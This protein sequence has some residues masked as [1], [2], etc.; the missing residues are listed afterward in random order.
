MLNK[1]EIQKKIYSITNTKKITKVMEMISII[2]MKKIKNKIN[3]MFDYFHTLTEIIKKLI[4]LMKSKK[5][6]NIF[7]SSKKVTRIAFIIV[8]TS[9]G[10]C[11]GLN[12]NLFKKVIPYLKNLSS[13]KIIYKLIILGKKEINFFNQFQNN[14]KIYDN[15][16][17]KKLN[18]LNSTKTFKTLFSDYKLNKFDKILIAFNQIRNKS[19][20][21]S[22]IKT[23]FPVSLKNNN[24]N[25]INQNSWDYVYESNINLLLKNLFN[26]FFNIKIYYSVLENLFS[27]YSSR[28]ISM[29]N[30][31]ENS[32]N[33]IQELNLFYNK[34]RQDSITQELTEIIS[35][36]SEVLMD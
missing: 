23:L 15:N 1:K 3:N 4:Y 7:I 29:K 6:T 14:I 9:K 32:S 26:Q 28:V 11:G 19:N 22:V 30:A 24:N 8:L 16:F 33:L 21:T 17:F 10:L 35:G 2:K 12:N 18:Y 13:K 20:Y 36:A 31:T 27:E 5:E 34:L 25:K